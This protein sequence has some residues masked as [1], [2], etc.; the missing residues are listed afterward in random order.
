MLVTKGK[1][2]HI[3][4]QIIGCRR[5]VLTLVARCT[6]GSRSSLSVTD[7][8]V[9]VSSP[10]KHVLVAIKSTG[11]P[12]SSHQREVLSFERIVI[13]LPRNIAGNGTVAGDE[14]ALGT[15]RQRPVQAEYE[16]GA[17]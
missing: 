2:D 3:G 12:F 14:G 13:P 8:S 5:D 7:L 10:T 9:A 1:G 6:T 11:V 15:W 4:A 16:R 17:G